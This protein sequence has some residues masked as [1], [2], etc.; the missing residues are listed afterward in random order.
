MRSTRPSRA[1]CRRRCKGTSGR[2]H[3]LHR[4]CRFVAVKERA[5]S[6]SRSSTAHAGL[7]ADDTMPKRA[8]EDE[9]HP[10]KADAEPDDKSGRNATVGE[11]CRRDERLE[12]TADEGRL[13]HGQTDRH[14]DHHRGRKAKTDHR[15]ARRDCGQMLPSATISTNFCRMRDGLLKNSGS[16]SPE[17]FGQ[18]PRA[19]HENGHNDS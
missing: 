2:Q 11:A 6:T 9:R 1:A 19:E 3:H 7:G 4:I 5:V 15:G 16:T 14:A 12:R 18:F 10:R 17:P 13:A 8:D